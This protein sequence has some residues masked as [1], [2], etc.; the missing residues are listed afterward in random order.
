MHYLVS[1][2]REDDRR[3]LFAEKAREAVEIVIEATTVGFD[4][5]SITNRD[6]ET[7]TIVELQRA[8]IEGQSSRD[9]TSL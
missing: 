6:N 2:V 3:L 1:L 9:Q 4:I 5:E 8:V 7:I